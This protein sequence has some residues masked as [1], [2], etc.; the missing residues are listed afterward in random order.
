MKRKIRIILMV[1]G[2]IIGLYG[3]LS[4]Y[5]PVTLIGALLIVV[6]LMFPIWIK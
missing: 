5:E 6:G 4:D 2:L 3:A 1:I